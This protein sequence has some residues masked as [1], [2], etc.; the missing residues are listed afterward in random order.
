VAVAE[1]T[2]PRPR[3]AHRRVA[4]PASRLHR[5][6]PMFAAVGVSCTIAYLILYWVLRGPVGA[7]AGNFLA[8]LVT[9]VANTAAN[10]RFTF[11]VTGP[12]DAL[13]H[14]LQGGVAFVIGL[15]LSS[16]ALA[17][18]HV[19]DPDASKTTE[20]T[21]LIS[22]NAIATAVRFLLLRVWIFRHAYPKKADAVA[23]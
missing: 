16:A 9:A 19:A 4:P 3:P 20:L 1:V 6:L 2:T 12:G 22:A 15:V 17:V 5:Q 21:A 13:R 10:R 7:Q 14:Q 8:A 23:L 11:R 18:L